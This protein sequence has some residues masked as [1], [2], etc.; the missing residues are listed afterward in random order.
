MASEPFQVLLVD[1]DRELST[2]LG[3][4]I[5]LEGFTVDTADS[6]EA[7]LARLADAGTDIVVLDVMMPHMSGIEVLRRLRAFSG[8][9]VLMLTARGDDIDCVLALELGADDYVQKPCPP[10]ELVARLR[11]I[12]RRVSGPRTHGGQDE[13]IVVGA[14]AVWPGRRV[15]EYGSTPLP[16]TG[17]EYGLLE[18]LARHAGSAVSK[19]DLSLQALGRPMGPYDRNIDVHVSA[20]RQKLAPLAGGRMLIHTVRGIGYQLVRD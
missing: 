20:L 15:A 13:A 17:S 14:L 8:V 11:A 10:R 2:L 16:L 7:A 12:L 4:Y 18:V 6:G 5:A 19:N 1:D 9:P 3:E